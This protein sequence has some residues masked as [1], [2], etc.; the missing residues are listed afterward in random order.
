MVAMPWFNVQR[1]LVGVGS[2]IAAFLNIPRHCIDQ[3]LS[4]R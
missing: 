2:V 1:S 4:K 3:R